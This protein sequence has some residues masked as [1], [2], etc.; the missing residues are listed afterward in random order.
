M[1]RI[2]ARIRRAVAAMAKIQGVYPL[3]RVL[4]G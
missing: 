3:A 2:E 1:S 4:F